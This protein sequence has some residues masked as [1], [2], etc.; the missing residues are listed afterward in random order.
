VRA[1]GAENCRIHYPGV[2]EDKDVVVEY[3]NR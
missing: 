2:F 1:E 3:G